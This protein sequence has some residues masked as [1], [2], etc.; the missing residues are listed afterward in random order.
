V[1]IPEFT[2]SIPSG[3]Q[4]CYCAGKET[5]LGIFVLAAEIYEVLE[6]QK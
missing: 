5:A 1:Y 3:K 2:Q 4:P 6:E